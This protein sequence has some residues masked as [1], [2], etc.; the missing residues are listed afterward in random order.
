[1]TLGRSRSPWL[2]FTPLHLQT[3]LAAHLQ[4]KL[5]DRKI[6]IQSGL[7]GNLI[8]TLE[9]IT[10]ASLPDGTSSSRWSGLTSMPGS[11]IAAPER[12]AG[13][14]ERHCRQREG[15]G[16]TGWRLRW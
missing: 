12:G 3:F 8:G 5:P 1:M 2:G 16:F 6:T 7:Y 10:E 4:Q 13:R 9:G 11:T 14:G 15:H